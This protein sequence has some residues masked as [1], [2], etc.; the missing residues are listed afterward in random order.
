MSDQLGSNMPNFD[1]FMQTPTSL[2]RGVAPTTW[3]DPDEDFI[4]LHGEEYDGFKS[5]SLSYGI[6]DSFAQNYKHIHAGDGMYSGSVD[7]VMKIVDQLSNTIGMFANVFANEMEVIVPPKKFPTTKDGIDLAEFDGHLTSYDKLFNKDY[8]FGDDDGLGRDKDVK[9]EVKEGVKE[10][11]VEGS[12]TASTDKKLPYSVDPN[13]LIGKLQ[14]TVGGDTSAL[15]K[16]ATLALV[17][18]E[19][20][21]IN[22]KVPTIGKAGVKSSAQ[23]LLEEFQK[24]AMGSAMDSKERVSNFDLVNGAM[25][26]ALSGAAHSISQKLLDTLSEQYGVGQGYRSQVHTHADSDQTWFS[27]K[28]LDHFKKNLGAFDANSIKQQV[29]LTKDNITVFDMTM[30]E[31]AEKAAMAIDILKKAGSNIDNETLEKLGD[32]GARYQSK[33]LSSIGAKGLMDLLGVKNYKNDGKAQKNALT[34]DDIEKRRVEYERFVKAQAEAKNSQYSIKSF[35]GETMKYQLVNMQGEISKVTIAWDDL[36]DTVRVVSDTSTSSIDAT[37]NKIQQY[38]SEIASAQKELLLSKGD[39][40]AFVAAEKAVDKIVAKIEGRKST[41]N[42]EEDQRIL[43]ALLDKLEVAR[44]KLA[45][46]GEKLHKLIAKNEKLRGG[47]TEVKQAITQGARVRGLIDS[48]GT[49]EKDG[50]QLFSVDD[51]APKYLNDYILAYNTLIETQQKYIKDGSINSAK[52]QDD[53]KVQTAGVKK[54]GIEAMA[55]YKKTQEL[56]EKSDASKELTYKNA[57]G[58]EYALGGSTRIS[59]S[60]VNRETMLKYAKEVLGADLASVKLNTTTGKLTG[61]LRK[62]NYVVADMA[63]EYDKATGQ[64]HLYQEKERESLSGMPGFLNGLKAKSKA[65]IQYVMSM[66]SIYRVLGEVR[67]G[68]QYVKEIDLAL[69]ELRKVTDETEETYDKFLRTAAKTGERLGATISAVTE[70]TATFA[71]LGYSMAQ[72]TEMA[73]AAIVYKNVGD[74]IASTEDAADSIIST[75]KGFGLE[76]TESMA[77]VDKFN[78]VGNRFAITSQGIGEALRLS[79]SALNEGKNSLDESIALITAANEVVNDPSSVGTALKTLTLRLRGSKT[80]LEE[81]GEDVTDMATTTSQ[82]QA[83]LL[84]LT[85]GQV[86]IMADANTF[87]NSTQILREMAA[88]WEDMTD[89]QRAE[90]CPYAQ[91]CA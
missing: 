8:I 81:M 50:L 2:F 68:I 38:K 86:D 41:G 51:D 29:L 25:S 71:K 73:E 54:L 91:K 4:D 59:Q 23:N 84:A 18:S 58:T 17:L 74:N 21:A 42:P 82:L 77:I 16:Q 75:M 30:V 83:K 69:T 6:A 5:A 15:A 49:E 43:S 31:T 39:D 11:V 13:S 7:I 55:A 60:D 52:V 27:A 90:W 40:S 48:I 20:Q 14:N 53:L 79:A 33:N 22:K 89:I 70:A 10:G 34:E 1:K 57:M 3:Y 56:Q 66:T 64:L 35:D 28:D 37:V 47:T 19:L 45:D 76:A 63:M 44:Q 80:E 26:P 46:E 32:L 9:A 36:K 61:V 12:K 24:M 65:I 62:S 88:A 87:K 85:G 67:K 72:A 78:E